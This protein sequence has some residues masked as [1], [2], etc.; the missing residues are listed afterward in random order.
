VNPAKS[1]PSKPSKVHE[2]IDPSN[3]PCRGE[4][5]AAGEELGADCYRVHQDPAQRRAELFAAGS[6]TRQRLPRRGNAV[7]VLALALVA[8]TA[9]EGGR[10][11]VDAHW[12][13]CYDYKVSDP[14]L[15]PKRDEF[16][17]PASG[18]KFETNCYH[19]EPWA[20]TSPAPTCRNDGCLLNKTSA[21]C[22][23]ASS[24]IPGF[25]NPNKPADKDTECTDNTYGT[26]NENGGAAGVCPQCSEGL[27]VSN[28]VGGNVI[29]AYGEG[30]YRDPRYASEHRRTAR[31]LAR[32]HARRALNRF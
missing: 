11:G 5:P 6:Q 22:C 29:E 3:V 28:G 32:A 13:I 25:Q 30:E 10:V 16:G 23:G 8:G 12:P 24:T 31:R 26:W 9:F 2:W 15:C 27:G 19:V 18:N 20:E 7:A 14:E 4:M 1:G 17:L 21:C